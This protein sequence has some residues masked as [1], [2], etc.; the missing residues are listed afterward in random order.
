MPSQKYWR[1]DFRWD[2][3][4]ARKVK[5]SVHLS[6]KWCHLSELSGTI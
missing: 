2:R 4:V 5:P 3:F 1:E 6:E